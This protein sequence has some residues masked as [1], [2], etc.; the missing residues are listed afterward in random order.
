MLL[1]PPILHAETKLCGD[2]LVTAAGNFTS[3][4]FPREYPNRVRCVWRIST[5][6]RRR[7]ALGTRG[8][9]FNV[10]TGS[11]YWSCNYDFVKVLDG[12]GRNSPQLGVFCGGPNFPKTFHTVYSTTPH[13]FVE[14]VSDSIV[15][16]KGFHLQYTTFFAGQTKSDHEAKI[17]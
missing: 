4:D 14:F 10:E 7:I 17:I 13:M 3:L 9:E 2:L 8:S 16:K 6:S 12:T 5:E 11:N 1:P 15:R